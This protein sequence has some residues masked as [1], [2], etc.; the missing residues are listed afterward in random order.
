M[1]LGR[2]RESNKPVAMSGRSILFGFTKLDSVEIP[3]NKKSAF[4][5]MKKG[6][7]K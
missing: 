3:C 1:N 2:Y 7:A 5:A 4:T 6:G